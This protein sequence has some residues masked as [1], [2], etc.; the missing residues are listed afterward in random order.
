MESLY[1]I[2]Y[3]YNMHKYILYASQYI[4]LIENPIEIKYIHI[5]IYNY[6]AVT[7]N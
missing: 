3:S 1:I 2:I 4:I 6:F 7:Y 5:N